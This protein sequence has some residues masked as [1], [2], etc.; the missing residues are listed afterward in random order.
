MKRLLILA[1]MTCF[2]ASAGTI[3]ANA[4]SLPS[5]PNGLGVQIHFT[6]AP[7]KDLDMIR[8]AGFKFVRVDL[9]WSRIETQKGVYNWTAYD[10]LLAGLT[11]RGI[12]PIFEL[13]FNNPD[14]Y[15]GSYPGAI[16]TSAQITAYTK[17][18]AAAAAHYKGKGVIFEIWNEPNLSKFWLPS[19]ST[20]QYT[21][22]TLSAIPAIKAADPDATIIAPAAAEQ[23]GTG[24][25]PFTFLEDC[26]K[27]GI[28]KDI[29]AVSIHPYRQPG[30]ENAIANIQQLKTLI[31]KYSPNKAIPII[32]SEWGYSTLWA[33]TANDQTQANYLERM[34]LTDMSLGMPISIWYDFKDDSTSTSSFE[35]RFGTVT[36]GYVPKAAYTAMQQLSQALKGKQFTR[37][38]SSSSSADY[39]LEFSDGTNT[40]VAAWTTGST[41]NVTIGTQSVS[42]STNPIYVNTATVT[43]TPTPTPTP[44]LINTP[45][46]LAVT[47]ISKGATTGA[48]YINLGWT[49]NSSNE[50]GFEVQQ[51]V[52]STTNFTAIGTVAANTKTYNA[53]IGTAPAD[54]TYY[55]Y[56]VVATDSTNK[57]AFSNVAEQQVG[58]PN[59]AVNLVT[60]ITKDAT[61]GNNIVNLSWTDKSGIEA[62]YK[63]L[64][65]TSP[66]SGFQVVKTVNKDVTSTTVD[67]GQ[68]AGTYYFEV[69]AYSAFADATPT[70]VTTVQSTSSTP[71]TTV[72]T[73]ASGLSVANVTKGATTGNYFVNLNWTDNSSN[74][75]GFEVQQ[76]IGTTD[77]FQ[78]IYT[79]AAGATSFSAN[80][81]T[82]P[83]VGNYYYRIV[84]LNSAGKA[85]P[86]NVAS[87]EIK[88]P[89]ST[90]TAASALSGTSTKDLSGNNAVIINWQDNSTDETGFNIYQSN[91]ID[92]G[93][94]KVGSVSANQN[95]V[96]Q[97]L[98]ASTSNSSLF[99]QIK[100]FNANGESLISNT[101]TVVIK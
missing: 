88:A 36:N 101:A 89:T 6:G 72:P 8:D 54:G 34:F 14:L 94:T 24:Q 26:F 91:L 41:H 35:Y 67:L 84:A 98:P 12:K 95:S 100:A 57:S 30:P 40:T 53:N 73:A 83:T 85:E 28:L 25:L 61:T 71:V 96:V 63:I 23:P 78:P 20:S 90:P 68:V 7:T 29:D 99:Y 64:Q 1:A 77:N 45:S 50:T 52:N 62:G 79:T 39:L 38:L 66:T 37:R 46:N 51:A 81:G 33:A 75:T 59:S 76:S 58:T 48:Y 80:I 69:V 17:Y 3:N 27:Q 15:G 56:R 70:N 93:F 32:S 42:I 55:R 4:A 74:E 11:A 21:A 44:V 13:V 16:S 87:A 5:G 86:S 43:P 92:S 97:I 47:N 22:M 10:Q 19:A 18:A 82:S 60:T 31:A 2:V 65:S 49:D 9:T